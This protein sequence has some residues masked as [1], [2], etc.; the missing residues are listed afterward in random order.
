M[1][2]TL[3]ALARSLSALVLALGIALPGCQLIGHQR[4]NTELRGGS[5][6]PLLLDQPLINDP[7]LTEVQSLLFST[8]Y[9]IDVEGQVVP[10]L[11]TRDEVSDDG[12]EWNLQLAGDARWHDDVPF[13]AVDVVATL[14]RL[15]DPVCPLALARTL[16]LITSIEA[17]GGDRV[18]LKL[19]APWY[20]LRAALADIPILPAHLLPA[21]IGGEPLSIRIGCGPYRLESESDD[22][23]LTLV[24]WPHYHGTTPP[25]EQLELR[26]VA[27]DEE[28]AHDVLDGTLGLITARAQNIPL[29]Q[30]RPDITVIRME[31]GLTLQIAIATA[32]A[33]F[34]DRR[35][36]AALSLLVDR[37]EIVRTVLEGAGSARRSP[38]PP[39]CSCPDTGAQRYAPD[40]AS[41]LLAQAGFTR[42][43]EQPFERAG[44]PLTLRMVVPKED[45]LARRASEVLATQ[46]KTAGVVVERYL[47]GDGDEPRGY[48]PHDARLIVANASPSAANFLY[49]YLHTN[50]AGNELD[51]RSPELDAMID[52]LAATRGKEQREDL[53]LKIQGFLDQEV[54][55]VPLVSPQILLATRVRVDPILLT[56]RVPGRVDFAQLLKGLAPPR[57]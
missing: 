41:D 26:Y 10:D 25:F 16:S 5:A 47:A 46:L 35:V 57:P 6:S 2:D 19:S 42:T 4:W 21:Q 17:V 30:S 55:L 33:P 14:Q 32:T 11:V 12:L 7:G 15:C 48:P 40:V 28:R 38:L 36:R 56:E 54:P 1:T 23:I 49:Y 18:R 43:E 27:D 20:D 24:R 9:E 3:H 44:V 13:S 34:D 52:S 37:E 45:P 29:L 8:L 31:S 22:G 50:G 39:R 53:C 51:Y